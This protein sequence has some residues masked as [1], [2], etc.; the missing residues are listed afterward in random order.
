MNRLDYHRER[1]KVTKHHFIRG[2]KQGAEGKNEVKIENSAGVPF[3]KIEIKGNTVVEIKNQALEYSSYLSAIESYTEGGVS[4]TYAIKLPDGWQDKELTYKLEEKTPLSGVDLYLATSSDFS[5]AR[6]LPLIENG[7][8]TTQATKG[9]THLIFKGINLEEIEDEDGNILGVPSDII[10]FWQG[11]SLIVTSDAC[12][13]FPAT[14]KSASNGIKIV[15]HSENLLN[16]EDFISS[17]LREEK[18]YTGY[19]NDCLNTQTV[20]NI[21]KKGVT[22]TISYDVEGIED[23]TNV[24][25]V[26]NGCGFMFWDKNLKRSVWSRCNKYPKLKG[27]IIHYHYTFQVPTD[28]EGLRMLVYEYRLKINGVTS[29]KSCIIRNVQI[30]EGAEAEEKP[31]QPYFKEEI[32]LPSSVT[33]DGKETPLPLTIYDRLIVDGAGK[34]VIYEK[35]SG[36]REF[37]GTEAFSVG[38]FNNDSFAYKIELSRLGFKEST[39]NGYSTH[40]IP[41]PSTEIANRGDACFEYS[42]FGEKNVC[43][44]YGTL[45]YSYKDMLLAE[46][47]FKAWLATQ[48]EAGTPVTVVV[49]YKE[50]EM[51]DITN[52]DFGK[53]LLSLSLEQGKNGYLCLK[54]EPNITSLVCEYY[55]CQDQ[56]KVT[57]LVSYKDKNGTRLIEDKSYPVRRGAYYQIS[58]PHIDGYTRE[59]QEVFGKADADTTIDLIYTEE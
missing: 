39:G 21:I 41:K 50:P 10:A 25:S 23:L 53:S 33:I 43:F 57:L 29:A 26:S 30:V 49:E 32:V 12:P 47:D 31:F 51:I 24:E 13:E 36:V 35:R 14:I 9:Y 42:S 16:K 6:L 54:S 17:A 22:Y 4:G 48:Y 19:G 2:T 44:L 52:T 58:V 28:F 59:M 46:N 56:S 20:Q 18:I 8:L 3:R 5:S 34:R 11:H 1:K 55:S 38:T 45:G 37:K 15:V 7:A 27:E 40:F